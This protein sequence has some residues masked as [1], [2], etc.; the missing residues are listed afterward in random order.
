MSDASRD[1]QA[2]HESSLEM[3]PLDHHYQSSSGHEPREGMAVEDSNEE[4][5]RQLAELR[6]QLSSHYSPRPRSNTAEYQAVQSDNT[7][8]HDAGSS[9]DASPQTR[10]SARRKRHVQWVGVQEADEQGK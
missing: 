6:R 4:R 5:E 8:S 2:R 3:Q 1:A 7:Q 9:G 10:L